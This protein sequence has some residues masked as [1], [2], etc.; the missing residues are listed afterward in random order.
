MN[1]RECRNTRREIDQSELHQALSE[2]ALAHIQSCGACRDFRDQRARLLDLVASLEPVTAP[3]DFDVRLRARLATRRQNNHQW[4]LSGFAVSMPATIAAALVVVLVGSI[5]WMAQR[6]R[7]QAPAIAA[8]PG[9]ETSAQPGAKP[10]AAANR[11]NATASITANPITTS[12]GGDDIARNAGVLSR[13]RLTASP[14]AKGPKVASRD[15]DESPAQAIRGSDNAGEVSLAA[16]VKPMVVSMQDD[17]GA[18]RK[19]SLPPVTFGSQR[20]VD[21]RIPVSA[22]GSRVW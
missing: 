1:R 7:I 3:A 13:R 22:T 8:A 20:L 2:V 5:V 18:T 17:R 19:F 15:L 6:N 12:S 16:P 10:S 4:S 9:A 21:N 14:L 11:S